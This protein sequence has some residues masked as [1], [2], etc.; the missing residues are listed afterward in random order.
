MSTSGSVRV[1]QVR[2]LNKPAQASATQWES[3]SR[4]AG[5]RQP[6]G[7]GGYR[8]LH[9][10]HLLPPVPHQSIGQ[11]KHQY[12]DPCHQPIGQTDSLN[13][14]LL[15]AELTAPFIYP[16]NKYLS[17]TWCA[18]DT[19]PDPREAEWRKNRHTQGNP[20]SHRC[21]RHLR[22]VRKQRARCT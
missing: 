13:T 3:G 14:H 15:S 20:H 18:T 4:G 22:G 17:R 6:C 9:P 21:I 8:A 7:T 16:F 11:K 12:V 5:N 19:D 2:L 10:G 1:G